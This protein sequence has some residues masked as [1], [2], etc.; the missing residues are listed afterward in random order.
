VADSAVLVMLM[1]SGVRWV[2]QVMRGDTA[3][4]LYILLA[5][6]SIFPLWCA[7]LA[8]GGP[9]VLASGVAYWAGTVFLS[10]PLA[11]NSDPAASTALFFIVAT[12]AWVGYLLLDR[13]VSWADTDLAAADS[14]EHE[15]YVALRRSTERREHERLLHDTVLNTLTALARLGKGE[16]APATGRPVEGAGGG[17]GDLREIVGRCRH[18]VTLMEYVLGGEADRAA[19]ARARGPHGPLLVAVE[20]IVLEMRAR[21]L[22]VHLRIGPGSDLQASGAAGS[23]PGADPASTQRPV[24]VAVA[25]A[26]ARAVREALRNVVRHAG[27]TQ[28]W[29]DVHLPELDAAPPD[30]GPLTVTVRDLGVGFDPGR[31]GPDRLGISRSIVERMEDCGGTA[32]V[33]SAPGHGTKVTL[34]LPA[35]VA[36]AFESARRSAAGPGMS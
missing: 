30:P 9:L 11:P 15:H 18:D 36:D 29:V 4:W 20:A 17:D 7:R 28:A 23:V 8:L 12:I 10:R 26:T 21:G 2:P 16:A 33:R 6:Q 14:A 34:R 3:S 27:T 1:L 5:A 31:V 32:A 19:G 24:P 13:K 25:M 22:D 35:A